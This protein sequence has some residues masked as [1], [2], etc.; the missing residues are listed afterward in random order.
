M[1]RTKLSNRV[2]P[3]Y[4]KG[5]EI[6]NMT[7]HI[8]G[9]ALGVTAL[10]LCVIMSIKHKNIYGIVGS[11]IYGFTLILLYSFSSIYHGLKPNTTAKKIF[12]ILDHCSIFILI[13]GTYTPIAL[14]TIRNVNTNDA[15]WLFGFICGSTIIG[16]ILNAIDLQSTK[17]FSM[18][19]YLL[20]GW[21]IVFKF[22]LLMNGMVTEGIS[23]LVA[24]GLAYT[25]GTV[26]YV[27][28]KKKKYFHSIF[29]IF[30]LLGS[31][32]QFFCILFYVV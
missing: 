12:Q 14:C 28:G 8:A 27:F 32:L 19:C 3:K 9:V 22:S 25:I 4:T 15:W 13:A 1:K 29:H 16:I 17:V 20:M 30:I 6:F 11:A 18:L 10:T 23:L 24:G 26:F 2:L 21:C 7:S 31:L 5:E